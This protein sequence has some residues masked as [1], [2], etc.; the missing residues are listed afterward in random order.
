MPG[1]DGTGPRGRGPMTGRGM[2]YCVKPVGELVALRAG[3]GAG[4]ARYRSGGVRGTGAA[5]YA[6]AGFPFIS[7]FR[8]V[9]WG[10]G[11]GGGRIGGRGRWW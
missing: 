11:R 1:F 6:A 5:P 9:R 3:A 7:F 4:G 8:W 10:R 2:G